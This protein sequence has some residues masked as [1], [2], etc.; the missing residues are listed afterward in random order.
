MKSKLRRTGLLAV[1]E[2]TVLLGILAMPLAMLARRAGVNL[3]VR[4]LIESVDDAYRDA[5]GR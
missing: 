3:P 1:Y 5:T 4:Q 2:L